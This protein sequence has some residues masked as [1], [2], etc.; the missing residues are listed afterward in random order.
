MN[1]MPQTPPNEEQ[2]TAIAFGLLRQLHGLPL[3]SVRAALE[4][5][6]RIAEANTLLDT[7]APEFANAESDFA[8]QSA[9]SKIMPPPAWRCAS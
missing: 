9:W 7:Q 2:M 5:A 4:T 3:S 6:Q 8:Q 1:P